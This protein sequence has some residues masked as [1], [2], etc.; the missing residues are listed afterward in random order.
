MRTRS[1]LLLGWMIYLSS[2]A[3]GQG[4][5]IIPD[6][7]VSKI[8]LG[9]HASTEKVLGARIWDK[10]FEAGG[11]L[12]RIEIVN[13]DTTQ[14]LRLLFHYGGSRNS[15]DEF[16]L[17]TIDKGYKLPRKAAKMDVVGFVT[18]KNIRL[19]MSRE[20]IVKAIGNKFKI[21]SNK[22]GGEEI[23]FELDESNQFVKRYNEDTYYIRCRFRNGVLVRYSFGFEYV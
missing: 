11:I 23:Y 10:C 7:S 21:V 8:K 19:G 17:L 13:R 2:P 12:P 14:V 18:S 4:R 22:G 1:L 6:T 16:E 15:V 5:A 20:S 9:D 3:I